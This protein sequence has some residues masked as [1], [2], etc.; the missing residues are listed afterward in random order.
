MRDIIA[1]QDSV[2]NTQVRFVSKALRNKHDAQFRHVS[3]EFRDTVTG[4]FKV[5]E[6]YSFSMSGGWRDEFCIALPDIPVTIDDIE[7][8]EKK[9]S[10]VYIFGC[11]DC[12]HHVADMLKLCYPV[13]EN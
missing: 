7:E 6:K 9:L 10:K 2:G 11:M 3:L 1:N 13:D 8:Y 4:R 5:S 12:R